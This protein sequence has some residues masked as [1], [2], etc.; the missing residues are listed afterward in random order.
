[1]PSYTYENGCS[2]AAQEGFLRLL[3]AQNRAIRNDYIPGAP[4]LDI[5]KEHDENNRGVIPVNKVAF[6]G[7]EQE[8]VLLNTINAIVNRPELEP[9]FS[10][11]DDG[12]FAAD[13]VEN[14]EEVFM[15]TLEWEET[16][17]ERERLANALCFLV[18]PCPIVA[19]EVRDA[20]RILNAFNKTLNFYDTAN[21][22]YK[23][24]IGALEIPIL[25]D[26]TVCICESGDPGGGAGSFSLTLPGPCAEGSSCRTVENVVLG[27]PNRYPSDGVVLAKSAMDYPGAKAVQMRGSNH[28]QMRNDE[29]TRVGLNQLWDGGHGIFFIT[30]KK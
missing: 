20:E 4:A 7:I 19:R 18:L 9:V 17:K 26:N 22:K 11:N 23:I 14:R 21:D 16:L 1:M 27:T 2:F 5:L 8:P 13:A 28:L 30:E 29:N 12:N 3:A 25:E 24:A 15:K 10:A 6:Y